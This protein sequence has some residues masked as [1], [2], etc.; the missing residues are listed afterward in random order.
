MAFGPFAPPSTPSQAKVRPPASETTAVRL[1]GPDVMG[2]SKSVLWGAS[3]R[4]LGVEDLMNKG[5]LVGTLNGVGEGQYVVACSVLVAKL[6]SCRRKDMCGVVKKRSAIMEDI[7][8]GRTDL[9]TN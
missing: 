5:T 4:R 2:P 6:V 3:M 7:D 8:V 1:R 9:H